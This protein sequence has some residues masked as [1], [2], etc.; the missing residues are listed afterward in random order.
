MINF[1]I[2]TCSF[3]DRLKE[4][5]VTPAFKKND[6]FLKNNYRPVSILPIPS[7]IFEKVLAEQLA[8]F[9]E[10]IFD[11]FLCA[12]RKGHGCQTTLL[13]LL[14]DWKLALEQNKYLAAILM[15]LSKAFDCLPHDI[16]ICKLSSYG[17]SEQACNLLLSYLSSRKQQI[18]VGGIVSQWA[19]IQKGVPQGSILG[20]LLFNVFINDIF[21]FIEKGNLYNYADDNT[22]S[23]CSTNYDNL[24]NVLESE[25]KILIDWFHF[26]CMQA[27]PEKFQAI[28]VGKKTAQKS[29][30]FNIC[31]FNITCDETVKLLGVDIDFMLNFDSHI[32]SICKKAAQQLNILKRIG[33]NLCKLSRLTIFH[34]FILSNFNFCPLS[35]HFCSAANTKKIEKIQERALR[36]VYCDYTSSYDE[37]LDKAKMPSLHIRRIRSMALETFKILHDLAPPVLSDLIHKQHHNYNFR[38]TNLL[39]IPHVKTTR[40]GKQSFRY[41]APVL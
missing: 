34:T 16:L 24:I 39:Q 35:W 23:Y 28:A 13:K 4:A 8:E 25:S 20:P 41:A 27:N 10:I 6:P 11:K 3:P 9:F 40:Y 22:L 37:L 38:Y 2:E 30:T 18:K 31:D 19:D 15:D 12:F 26:N 33:R 36:Y 14:E 7:K 17:L 5:Q 21:Y 29:P 1:T 32:K